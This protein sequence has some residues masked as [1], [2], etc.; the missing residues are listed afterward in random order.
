METTGNEWMG[1][2]HHFSRPT[3]AP[4][5]GFTPYPGRV[6]SQGNS[7]DRMSQDFI[8]TWQANNPRQGNVQ[9]NTSQYDTSREM[10]NFGIR[11]KFQDWRAGAPN[12]RDNR[13]HNRG[14][15][16]EMTDQNR[17]ERNYDPPMFA[18]HGGN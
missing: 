7:R 1:Q 4:E 17:A 9:S 2:G 16:R 13:R 5:G 15:R 18:A 10:P 12:R 11:D 8:D 14:V 3:S 6:D